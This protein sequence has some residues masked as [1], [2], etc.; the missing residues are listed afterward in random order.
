M[1]VLRTIGWF[2]TCTKAEMAIGGNVA[3]NGLTPRLA[4]GPGGWELWDDWDEWGEGWAEDQW[5]ARGKQAGPQLIPPEG[6]PVPQPQGTLNFGGWE[7]PSPGG[8]PK[9]VPHGV[10][11][12]EI[13]TGGKGQ[14][15]QWEE[16]DLLMPSRCAGSTS[17][18]G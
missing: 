3:A 10:P 18:W 11:H 15:G 17:S 2:A 13:Q 14:Q 8:P 5:E 12:F 1:I 7:S 6:S 16:E 9:G 4:S